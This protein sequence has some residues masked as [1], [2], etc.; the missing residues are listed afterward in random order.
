[1]TL[2]EQ[3]RHHLSLVH[4]WIPT[5]V[6]V[7]AAAALIATIGWRTRRWRL[8]WLPWAVLV[9][10]ALAAPA[11]WYVASEGLAG[12]PAPHSLWIWIGLSGVAAGVL[13]AGWRGTRWW[14]RGASVL[15]LPLCLLS[16]AL[17]LNLRVGY[18]PT[19]QTAW[20]QL[21]GCPIRRIGSP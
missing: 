5:T 20:N 9:G 16:A 18:F 10:V 3:I 19:V 1:V 21:T 6:Q 12:N 7:I 17:A 13:V 8:V 14:R 2:P 11:Y 4:G 15:A